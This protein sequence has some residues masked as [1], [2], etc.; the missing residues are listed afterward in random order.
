MGKLLRMRGTVREQAVTALRWAE[1]P[2][3]ASQSI[4][5]L[6]RVLTERNALESARSVTALIVA[7]ES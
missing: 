7:R 6:D 2:S 3:L 4:E 1:A 5:R